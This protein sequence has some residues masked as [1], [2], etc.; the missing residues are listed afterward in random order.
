MDIFHLHPKEFSDASFSINL[1][2]QVKYYRVHEIKHTLE[3]E[4]F[5]QYLVTG[6]NFEYYEKIA[7]QDIDKV[8]KFEKGR[9]VYYIYVQPTTEPS[10]NSDVLH[11][12]YNNSGLLE[13][14][15]RFSK[16]DRSRIMI[17]SITSF[18]YRRT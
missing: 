4:E 13:W 17:F 3:Y 12:Y 9:P 14:D 7:P 8:T 11:V 1:E 16:Y 5:D 6:S 18:M 2:E 10:P 15:L